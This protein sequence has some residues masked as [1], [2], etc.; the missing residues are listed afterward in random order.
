MRFE[1][2]WLLSQVAGFV[3][4]L[5]R[6]GSVFV[7]MPLFASRTAPMPVRA[8]LAMMTTFALLPQLPPMPHTELLSAE[9]LFIAV[10]QCLIGVAMGFVLH[11]VFAAIVFGGQS[12]AYSMGLGFASM[13]D[14]MTGVQVPVIAQLYQLL[15]TLL[16]LSMDGHLMLLRV[17]AESFQTLPVGLDGLSRDAL[18]QLCRWSAKLLAAGWLLSLPMVAALLLVNLGF[19]VASRA[20][21]Q[22]NIFSVGFPIS[23]LLGLYLIRLSLPD[24]LSLFAGFLDDGYQLMG[25]IIR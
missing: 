6:V 7:A 24:T 14:P 9:G 4:A 3:W 21:P 8:M 13:V 23:L 20:A 5:L 22:L 12:V 10:Q 1:E 18:W 16:F 25:R 2:A 15:A 19:G 17:L 11:M